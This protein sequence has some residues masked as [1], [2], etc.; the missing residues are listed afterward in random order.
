MPGRYGP[1]LVEALAGCGEVLINGF[2]VKMGSLR[3]KVFAGNRAC[4]D[5]GREGTFYMLRRSADANAPTDRAHLNLWC[6]DADGTL[7]LMTK[8]H[9]LPRARGGQDDLANLQTMCTFCNGRKGCEE[10]L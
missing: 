6:E 3:Y 5:C 9:I 10:P 8:D 7:V 2:R 4:V 1:E